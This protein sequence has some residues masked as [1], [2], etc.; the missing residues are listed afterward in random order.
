MKTL[1]N[2]KR[3]VAVTLLALLLC[4][5]A[6]I[7]RVS[8]ATSQQDTAKVN[9]YAGKLVD[10]LSNRPLIF[11]NVYVVGYSIGTVSNADGEFILKVPAN[12]TGKQLGVTHLG[13]KNFRVALSSLKETDN[14][15]MLDPEPVPI[16]EVIIRSNDPL[17]LLRAAMSRI[18]DNY[19]SSP[20]MLTGFYRETIKK[21]RAYAEVAEA[22]LDVYKGAY[23]KGLDE[24]RV[25]IFKGRKSQDVERMDT[26]SLKLQGG[27]RTVFMLDVV[28]NPELLLDEESFKFYRYRLGGMTSV[29][30]K[31][32]YVIEFSPYPDSRE[33]L[34]EGKIYLDVNNLAIIQLEFQLSKEGLEIADQILVKKKPVGLRVETQGASYLVDYSEFNNKWYLNYVRTE[35]RFKCKWP[36]KI[37]TSTFTVMSEMAVTDISTENATRFTFK[38][39]AKMNDV[40]AD[41]V[42]YFKDD[43][44]WGSYNYIKPDE[45]IQEAIQ[46][47]NK[48]IIR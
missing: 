35:L 9:S 8:A 14:L 43:S 6:N 44:F 25:K 7:A 34:Y 23:T 47:L 29:N 40:F 28:K 24:D 45:S 16:S 18:H 38:E 46:K 3:N 26:V 5:T 12:L 33:P 32:C 20:V 21:N 22:I 42:D 11:A 1:V 31:E 13:Y 10:K 15:L 30:D 48:K 17:S 19:S 41:Q 4:A 37:F 36:K 27:P 2:Y 39:S